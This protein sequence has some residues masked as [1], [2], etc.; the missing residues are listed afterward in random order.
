MQIHQLICCQI[1]RFCVT[2]CNQAHAREGYCRIELL[3]NPGT[4][5][6]RLQAVRYDPE[7][8]EEGI[9]VQG[10]NGDPDVVTVREPVSCQTAF[11][12]RSQQVIVSVGHSHDLADFHVELGGSTA[13]KVHGCDVLRLTC[14]NPFDCNLLRLVMSP[15]SLTQVHQSIKIHK[16]VF[17]YSRH[18]CFILS[19]WPTGTPHFGTPVTTRVLGM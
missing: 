15:P 14:Q 13:F 3:R 6:Q 12:K 19:L 9:T 16:C 18:L 8:L 1:G 7:R 2:L 10:S 11:M 5:G 4:L 17:L